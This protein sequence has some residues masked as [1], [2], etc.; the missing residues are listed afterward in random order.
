MLHLDM[1]ELTRDVIENIQRRDVLRPRVYGR[2]GA[3][4]TFGGN[5]PEIIAK[6]EGTGPMDGSVAKNGQN[7]RTKPLNNLDSMT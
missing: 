6:R 7:G 3:R 5:S 1:V 2:R 4:A